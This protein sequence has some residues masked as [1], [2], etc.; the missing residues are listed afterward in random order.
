MRFHHVARSA[1]MLLG[2]A[3]PLVSH[4]QFQAPT[5]EELKMI[6]DPKAPGADAV[7][8]YREE[9]EDDPHHFRTVYARIKVLTEKGKDLATVRVTYS[10]NFVFNATGNNSSRSS[11]AMESHFDAPDLNHAGEDQHTDKGRHAEAFA[12][13]EATLAK[14]ALHKRL[15]RRFAKGGG[16]RLLV[17]RK[18]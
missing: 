9:T 12:K 8:L 7:Y 4:A 6:S 18:Y 1:V 3:V 2:A 14:V 11:S 5:P 15:A 13:H 16:E 10:R 17:R